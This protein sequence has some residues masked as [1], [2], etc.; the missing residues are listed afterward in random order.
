MG[1]N[2][3]SSEAPILK[4]NVS[5]GANAIIIGRVTIGENAVIG[6]GAFVAK[7]VDENTVVVGNPARNVEYS[8]QKIA[9]NK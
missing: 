4:D 7:D 6:A 3:K 5:V 8:Q 1:N 2:G 9:K